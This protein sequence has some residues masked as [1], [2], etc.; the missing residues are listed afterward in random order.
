MRLSVFLSRSF[1]VIPGVSA[2]AS[3]FSPASAVLEQAI[4]DQAFPGCAVAAGNQESILWS[5]GFG[6]HDYRANQPVSPDTVYD[7]ASLT[8]VVGTTAVLMRL[9]AHCKLDVNEPVVSYI[10]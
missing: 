9:V 4:A 5:A 10:P 2:L 3:D 8:K 1:L 6:H 7:L